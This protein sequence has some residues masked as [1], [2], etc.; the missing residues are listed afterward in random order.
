M[1]AKSQSKASGILELGRKITAASLNELHADFFDL[2]QKHPMLR[3]IDISFRNQ[4]D[5]PI[6]M[7]RQSNGLNMP[8][9]V[10]R[11]IDQRHNT[12]Q[13]LG[14][15]TGDIQRPPGFERSLLGLT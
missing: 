13:K 2:R 9:E 11:R 4:L 3:R 14:Q 7:A 1:V 15:M 6:A 5:A 8:I 10:T 12:G